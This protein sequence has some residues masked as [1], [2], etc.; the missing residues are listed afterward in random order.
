MN[1]ATKRG[2]FASAKLIVEDY[3]RQLFSG[4]WS[5]WMSRVSQRYK[6]HDGEPMRHFQNFT[7][8]S[9]I[10]SATNY[11][12]AQ[13]QGMS[14]QR[15]V[16]R[17]QRSVIHIQT[18]A[19]VSGRCA[20]RTNPCFVKFGANSDDNRC[21]NYRMR[22]RWWCRGCGRQRRL[23]RFSWVWSHSVALLRY[24]PSPR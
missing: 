11:D 4:W 24:C 15:K 19:F 21:F 3:L 1:L 17:G 20:I 9:G 14:R 7:G 5:S 16:L 6:N 8:F 10:K 12:C 13:T 23:G 18:A 22:R 2:L